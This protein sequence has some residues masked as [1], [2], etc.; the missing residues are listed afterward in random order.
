[1]SD[2]Q[3]DSGAGVSGA[4]HLAEQVRR[5]L[6]LLDRL[7]ADDPVLE[8]L[9]RWQRARLDATYA[10]LAGQERFRDA[11]VFFL[12]ELYGGKDMRERDR[13]LE[14]V[15]PIMRRFLPDHLLFAVGEAM[16]LQWMSL[17]L[18]ARLAGHLAADLDQPEYARAYRELGAWQDREEQI[19]LIG[20][21]GRLLAETVQKKMIRRLVRWMRAPAEAAGVG[22]LQAFLMEGLDAFAVMGDRADTFV[23]TI[24][25][26]ERQALEAMRSGSDWPFEPWIGRGPDAA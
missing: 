21:L 1:M 14:R 18:D 23:E 24:E 16:R 2:A 9:Q 20:S 11:C 19:A 8:R 4:E 10:D 13:Q 5:S 17:D 22:R 12:D 26:R 3:G 6:D 25:T 7:P 15:V